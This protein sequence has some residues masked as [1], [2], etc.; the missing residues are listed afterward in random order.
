[1][2]PVTVFKGPT[3]QHEALVRVAGE[4]EIEGVAV[5]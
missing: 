2:V 3:K 4:R 5:G 1:V